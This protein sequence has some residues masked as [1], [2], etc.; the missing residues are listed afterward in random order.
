M[1]R[2]SLF[3]TANH[4]DDAVRAE[5]VT[6]DLNADIG[7]ILGGPHFGI[8]QRIERFVAPF[9]LIQRTVLAPQANLDLFPL[10]GGDIFQQLRNLMQLSRPDDHV[11]I[12]RPVKDLPLMILSHASD[13]ADDLFGV[14]LL[15]TFQLAQRTVNL[16]LGM[17]A[18]TARV[19]QNRV[20][21]LRFG[22]QLVTPLT[23][24]GDNHLA[25]ENVHLTANG[26]D[27]KTF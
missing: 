17:L 11:D 26:F 27:E 6:A 20:G 4:G 5:F 12:R 25:I 15:E 1:R 21:Q 18:H 13:H 23:Q 24:T 19:E 7:L 8:P 10:A 2:S 14:R 16:F 22:S 3:R 9:D